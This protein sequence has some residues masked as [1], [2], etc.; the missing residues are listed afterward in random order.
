MGTDSK[1][2]QILV[3]DDGMGGTSCIFTLGSR[4][5][6]ASPIKFDL[7]TSISMWRGGGGGGARP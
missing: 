1:S 5:R 4:L 3:E 7:V 2:S 6:L